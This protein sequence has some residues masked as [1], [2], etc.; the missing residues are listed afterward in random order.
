MKHFKSA[1]QAQRLPRF[2][3]RWQTSFAALSTSALQLIASHEL[4]SFTSGP[5]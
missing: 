2:M 3:M 1:P 4:R 5:R